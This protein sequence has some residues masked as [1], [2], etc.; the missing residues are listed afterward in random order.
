MQYVTRHVETDEFT[1]TESL[2]NSNW[3]FSAFEEKC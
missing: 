2:K 1:F 3:E